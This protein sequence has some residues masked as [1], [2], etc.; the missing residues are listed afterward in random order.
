V[1]AAADRAGDEVA[2]A[3]RMN[4]AATDAFF[5][6]RFG[7]LGLD[8]EG[9]PAVALVHPAALEQWPVVGTALAAYYAGAFW[10]GRMAVFGDGLPPGIIADGRR[11]GPSAR[12]LDLVAHEWTHGVIEAT[13]NFIYRHESGAIAEAFADIMGTAVEFATQSPGAGPMR[14]DYLI[15]EDAT[16]DGVRSLSDPSS[17]GGPD[18]VNRRDTATADNGGVHVNSTI[19]SHAFYLAVEGGIN[20]TSSLA[21]EGV[22]AANRRQLERVFYRAFVY[23]M[24]TS[25]SFGL[26]RA[27]TIQSARDLYGRD[28]PAERATVQAWAAVGVR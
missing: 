10:D 23:L 17:R 27:A 21:V 13:A 6:Q 9:T 1:R 22:G 5:R 8:G 3:A 28:S 2:A 24:P 20:A 25:A 18:H 15:G 26:A 11:W 12:A 14:A 7:R 19:V 16:P 4:L